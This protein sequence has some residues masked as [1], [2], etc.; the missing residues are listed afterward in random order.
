MSHRESAV[1]G[2]ILEL[3]F[4]LHMYMLDVMLLTCACNSI[5]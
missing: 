2:I 3:D 1:M 5:S 4:G